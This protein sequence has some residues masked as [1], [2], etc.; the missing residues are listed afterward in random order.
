MRTRKFTNVEL[1]VFIRDTHVDNL[2]KIRDALAVGGSHYLIP[3]E[4]I[5][6]DQSVKMIIRAIDDYFSFRDVLGRTK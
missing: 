2:Q 5:L 6:N 3:E 1:V 4:W